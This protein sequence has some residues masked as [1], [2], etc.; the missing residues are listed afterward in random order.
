M[1][2]TKP[3]TENELERAKVLTDLLNCTPDSKS[4]PENAKVWVHYKR[5]NTKDSIKY[6]FTITNYV[7]PEK[8]YEGKHYTITGQV[9]DISKYTGDDHYSRMI[10]YLKQVNPVENNSKVSDEEHHVIKY[11]QALYLDGEKKHIKSLYKNTFYHLFYNNKLTSVENIKG[12]LS[13]PE[14]KVIIIDENLQRNVTKVVRGSTTMIIFPN[15]IPIN[16][17]HDKPIT[18]NSLKI[19]KDSETTKGL[20]VFRNNAEKYPDIAKGVGVSKEDINEALNMSSLYDSITTIS[21]ELTNQYGNN[22]VKPNV[23]EEIEASLKHILEL[24]SNL[25]V[26][27]QTEKVSLES[28]DSESS[29]KRLKVDIKQETDNDL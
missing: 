1:S 27:T 29:K 8:E 28:K 12:L 6:T 11:N 7:T 24:F 15:D 25:K 21:S 9:I 14:T 18:K 3:A 5:N 23:V 20:K 10:S 17:S 26:S 2:I 16:N 19:I 22:M 4:A 13:H